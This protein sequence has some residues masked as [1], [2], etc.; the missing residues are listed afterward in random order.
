MQV[1]FAA[2]CASTGNSNNASAAAD[3]LH[4]GRVTLF[5]PALSF[6]PPVGFKSLDVSELKISLPENED[7]RNIFADDDQTGYVI[8]TYQDDLDVAPADL[9]RVKGFTERTQRG[10][11]DWIT[12]ELVEMNGR[13]WWHFETE[14]PVIS[15]L[16]TLVPPAG[17]GKAKAS[18]APKEE[19]MHR[20]A[21]STVFKIK[22][23]AF[24]FESSV[25]NYQ[26][27]NDSFNQSIQS[28][29]IKD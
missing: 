19:R 7:P 27:L 20:N 11:A 15:K 5:D 9:V 3:D 10:L 24:T 14:D 6:V 8:V 25:D 17:S 22:L 13:Q 4:D 29:Q 2:A 16:E 23:L 26:R 21:Y 18:P 1:W 28:I 12:S